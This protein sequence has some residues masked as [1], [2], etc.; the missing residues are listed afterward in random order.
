MDGHDHSAIALLDCLYLA[1]GVVEVRQGVFRRDVGDYLHLGDIREGDSTLLLRLL[2]LL[3]V[4]S[5]DSGGQSRGQGRQ[6][7]GV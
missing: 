3:L 7:R 6:S 2:P 1:S 5:I 4:L